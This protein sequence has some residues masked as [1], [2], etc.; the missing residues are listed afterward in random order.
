M[1]TTV[2]INLII[3][4]N[5]D[6]YGNRSLIRYYDL[7]RSEKLGLTVF[8]MISRPHTR[9]FKVGRAGVIESVFDH[10]LEMG[11]F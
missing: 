6:H 10:T 2:R 5:G 9:M 3:I 11:T 8:E 1:F 7:Q 4:I